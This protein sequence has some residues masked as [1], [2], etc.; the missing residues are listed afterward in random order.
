MTAPNR[1]PRIALVW[2]QFASHHVDRVSA[3]A[4][5]LEGKAQVLAIEVATDSREYADFGSAK[6][7]GKAERRTLF[8]G[9][10]FDELPRWRRFVAV[11]AAV[12]GCRMVCIGVPYNELEFVL[13]AGL[14]RLL[15]VRTVL[16]SVSKFD[17]YPRSAGFEFLKRLG[18]G[19]FSAVVVPGA[20]GREF[21][22][23][24]GFRRR[25]VVVGGNTIAIARVRAGA[26]SQGLPAPVPF[27]QRDFI[28]V[29]R[30][31]AKKNLSLLIAAFALHCQREGAAA[32]R[33]V[34]VG[35]GPLEA[36]LRREAAEQLGEGRVA[37]TGFLG[38]SELHSQLARSLALVLVSTSEQWGL[39]V[40]EA[41]A[42]G[43]PVIASEAPGAR[44]V[45]VR[46]LVNGFVTES[47]SVEGIARAL[48]QIGSGEADW[49]A[50]C[51]ASRRRAPLGDVAIFAEAVAGIAGFAAAESPLMAEY[52]RALDE[53]SGPAVPDIHA[54]RWRPN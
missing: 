39:V 31:I 32:R 49:Q 43:L 40:N 18:L 45:L 22:R 38:G 12:R 3:L 4:E 13:L 24:L 21:Y 48:Q 29:G 27:A 36:R 23:Y 2:S 8:P 14:L 30:F 52:R 46:N 28:Y 54:R 11:L 1:L 5:R 51:E 50:M 17:D 15:G 47:D 35:A 26:G 25:P 6:G 53:F 41:L 10:S 33:L 34:L 19:C 37:F 9:R 44:D 7:A 42:L 20:R 16:L